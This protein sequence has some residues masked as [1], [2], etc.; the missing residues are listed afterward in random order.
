MSKFIISYDLHNVRTY[1]PVWAKLEAWGAVRLLESVWLVSLNNTA[2][3]VRE[4]LRQAADNDDSI[5]VVELKEGS[6]WS[7]FNA[8][9]DGVQW[10]KTNIAS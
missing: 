6:N 1:P 5:A 8:R 2:E 4:A 9:P 7:T 3:Q 10:M